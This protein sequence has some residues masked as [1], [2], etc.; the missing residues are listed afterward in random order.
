MTTALAPPSVTIAMVPQSDD[1]PP[2]TNKDESATSR[3]EGDLQ[4]L[5]EES[6][7]P[8]IEDLTDWL[9]HLFG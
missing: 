3:F 4:R 9:S 2:T 5:Q 6:L 8:I 7:Q 1:L